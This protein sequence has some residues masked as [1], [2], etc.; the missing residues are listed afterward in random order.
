MSKKNRSFATFEDLSNRFPQPAEGEDCPI[1]EA[2][3]RSTFRREMKIGLGVI[4]MLLIVLSVVFVRRLRGPNEDIA[5]STEPSAEQAGAADGTGPAISLPSQPTVISATADTSVIPASGTLERWTVGSNSAGA[6]APEE[7]TATSPPS[8]MPRPVL[9]APS[10]HYAGYGVTET[11]APVS[12]NW[13]SNQPAA[14]ADQMQAAAATAPATLSDALSP[15]TQFTPA[16]ANDFTPAPA[17]DLNPLRSSETSD[18]S[19]DPPAL[20][21]ATPVHSNP[22]ADPRWGYAGSTP[23]VATTAAPNQSPV[24]PVVPESSEEPSNSRSTYRTPEPANTSALPA[25]GYAGTVESVLPEPAVRAENGSY[26]IQ[27]GDSYW[28]ISEKLYGTGGF[29]RALAEHNREKFP[30]ERKLSV[31]ETIMAPTAEQLTGE[32][33]GLCPKPGHRDVAV[34]RAR[35]MTTSTPVGCGK[36][37]SVQEGDSL[38]DIAKYELGKASRWVDIYELNRDVLGTQFDYL[39]PGMQLVLPDDRPAGTVTQRT[40]PNYQR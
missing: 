24:N 5:S 39:T 17:A 11:A 38:F 10:P 1:E 13:Q 23:S 19:V 15:Q 2:A 7:S 27:P 28:T 16:P 26:T 40:G 20:P 18:A 32:Y 34:Q 29:F 3:D 6:K 30:Q 8:Y 9:A 21:Q 37:Y 4:L 12:A 35:I 25:A 33:P 14:A 31:G 22:A 36:S